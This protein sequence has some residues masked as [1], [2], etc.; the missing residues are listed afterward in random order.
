MGRQDSTVFHSAMPAK[1]M[2]SPEVFLRG[3]GWHHTRPKMR[4]EVA[5]F[6]L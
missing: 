3:K 4:K 6:G 2:D 5:K 1:V